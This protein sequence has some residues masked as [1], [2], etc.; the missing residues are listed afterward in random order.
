MSNDYVYVVEFLDSK[1]YKKIMANFDAN[2]TEECK[3]IFHQIE[4]KASIKKIKLMS[5]YDYKHMI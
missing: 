1:G 2:S 5:E 4:P 3:K